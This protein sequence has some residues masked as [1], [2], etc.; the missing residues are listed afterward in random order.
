M[1][2]SGNDGQENL[3]IHDQRAC[4]HP[5][6]C[7]KV[8]LYSADSYF[9]EF[10]QSKGPV[11]MLLI[12]VEGWD[13]DVLFGASSVLERTQYLEFEYHFKGPWG[14][15]H[16]PDTV[17]LLDHKGFTCYWAGK[18]KLWRITGC[19]F[20]VYN[21]YHDHSNVA[22]VHRTYEKL[23]ERMENLFLATIEENDNIL[24][25]VDG[26]TVKFCKS[27][28][29]KGTNTS[30]DGRAQFLVSK[31]HLSVQDAKSSILVDGC[32]CSS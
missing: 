12:D 19:H 1:E 31:Y 17:R 6:D 26:S 2:F 30:C 27:N 14:R 13:F 8:P 28:K 32:Q 22:C 3:G 11:N 7:K 20:D 18:H 24:E 23:A 10:V 5:S 9:D 25:M 15:Y 29:W 21:T 4:Q 16:L